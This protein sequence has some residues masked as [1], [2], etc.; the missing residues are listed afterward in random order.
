VSLPGITT[1][2]LVSPQLF[3]NI[4]STRIMATMFSSFLQEIERSPWNQRAWTL[5]EAC[6]S[7]RLL[8]F[9]DTSVSL[10]CRDGLFHDAIDGFVP[11]V[12]EKRAV[13]RAFTFPFHLDIFDNEFGTTYFGQ[14]LHSYS[15]R[16]LTNHVDAL[17]AVSGLLTRYSKSTGEEF[18]FGL[19]KSHFIRCLIWNST[20]CVRRNGFPSWSLSY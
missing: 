4:N 20:N 8:C 7:R 5:Q 17:A 11:T 1:K 6:L 10:V 18:L 12:K 19:P 3:V 13:F 14:I 15:Q 9:T 2:L 16:Q